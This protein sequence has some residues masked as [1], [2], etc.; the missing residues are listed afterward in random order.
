MAPSRCVR[1]RAWRDRRGVAALEMAAVAPFLLFILLTC[2][3]FG[4]ALSQNIEL[5]HAVKA[6]AQ[7]SIT[8]SNAKTQID[9][10]VK[11]ALPSY[12]RKT[13][14]IT[15]TCYCGPMP[16]GDTAMP[17]VAPC[18]SACPSTSAR[19]MKITAKHSFTPLNFDII[20]VTKVLGIDEISSNVTV[21]H[22]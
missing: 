5:T 4:R 11:N 8:A 6:G 20:G 22:Q 13:A 19:M 1:S 14:I 3:D 17:P 18:D 16:A 7:Y 12:M 15:S 2:I 9:A 21:R 10:A